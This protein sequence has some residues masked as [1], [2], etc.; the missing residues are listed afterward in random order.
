[1]TKT[2]K[3]MNSQLNQSQ[4]KSLRSNYEEN[5]SKISLAP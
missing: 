5:S 4:A 3:M 2:S 1:M